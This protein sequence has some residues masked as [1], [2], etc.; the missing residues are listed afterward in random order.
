M[1]KKKAE[2]QPKA[3][4]NVKIAKV[5]TFMPE[6]PKIYDSYEQMIAYFNTRIKSIRAEELM[7]KWELGGQVKLMLDGKVYG[8]KQ[9]ANMADELDIGDTL[10]YGYKNLYM[11]YPREMIERFMKAGVGY[12]TLHKLHISS[13]PQKERMQVAEKLISGDMPKKDLDLLL[14]KYRTRNKALAAPKESG[15]DKKAEDTA[16]E[17]SVDSRKEAQEDEEDDQDLARP[18]ADERELSGKAGATFRQLVA[19]INAETARFSKAVDT[20]D[21]ILQVLDCICGEDPDAG[22]QCMLIVSGVISNMKALSGK[23][24]LKCE[25]M[26]KVAI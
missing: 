14:E 15:G 2:K 18:D 21:N 11:L 17:V 26:K 3:A 5:D 10:L 19:A 7:I 12:H 23:M 20:V 4:K 24:A 16:P 1:K 9:V 25:A 13:L 8:G 6:A 22:E